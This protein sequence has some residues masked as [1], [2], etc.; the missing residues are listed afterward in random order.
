MNNDTKRTVRDKHKKW[1]KYQKKRTASAWKDYTL[2]RNTATSEV[3]K[4]KATFEQKIAREV[5]ENPK[6]FWSYV[7]SQTKTKS[8]I[9]DLKKSDVIAVSTDLEKAEVLNQFFASVFTNEDFSSTPI[10]ERKIQDPSRN[11]DNV[12]YSPQN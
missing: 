12:E 7:K 4:A 6:S 10:C 9:A 2:A 1:K 3:R 8:G 5:E 11:L